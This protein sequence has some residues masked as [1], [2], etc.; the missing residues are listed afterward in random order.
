MLDQLDLGLQVHTMVIKE[1]G[2][3]RFD[4]RPGSDLN[5]P[6]PVKSS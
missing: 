1:I 3:R 2:H 6:W 4:K 5:S